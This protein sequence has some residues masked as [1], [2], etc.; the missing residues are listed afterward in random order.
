MLKKFCSVLLLLSLFLFSVRPAGAQAQPPQKLTHVTVALGD[1]SLNKLIFIVAQDAG[2]YKK[3]GLDVDQYITPGAAEVVRHSGVNIPKERVRAAAIEEAADFSIGGATPVIVGRVT[4]AR[5]GDRIT[6][7]S[8][9]NTVRWHI[10]AR[11]GITRPED[12]KG[13]KIGFSGVGAMTHFMALWYVKHMGWDP[14]MDVSLLSNA[15]ALDTLQNG[16]VDAFVADEIAYTMAVSAGYKSLV[17][18]NQFNVPIGGS[19]AYADRKWVNNNKDTVRRFIRAT[20]EAIAL[21]KQNKDVGLKAIAGWY[22]ITDREQQ[23]MLLL[24]LSK[25]PRKPYPAVEGLKLTM[26]LYDSHE[27]RSHKVEDFYDDSFVKELDQSGYI[28]SLYK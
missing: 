11:A 8:T 7:A 2:L 6:L 19:G 27:M 13:K 1:V 28:D 5:A 4:N 18:L 23:E 22:G 21:I 3:N 14:T 9:D 25:L 12:L 16:T 24:D 15:L 17:D 26:Q 20:V 10:V